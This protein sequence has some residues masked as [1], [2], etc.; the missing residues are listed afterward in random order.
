MLCCCLRSRDEFVVHVSH[1]TL[2]ML[3][4]MANVDDKC[5]LGTFM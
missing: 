5:T 2:H 3:L 4:A 1:G